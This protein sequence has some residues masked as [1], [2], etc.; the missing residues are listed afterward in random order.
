MLLMVRLPPF[1][2][3][4]SALREGGYFHLLVFSGGEFRFRDLR[5]LGGFLLGENLQAKVGRKLWGPQEGALHLFRLFFYAFGGDVSFSV[6]H[7]PLGLWCLPELA[8]VRQEREI[9]VEE[10]R[11]LSPPLLLL[12]CWTH[13]A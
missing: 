1:L 2:L 13:Q 3:G 6:H 10:R 7:L 12:A 9:L 5:L 4:I 11:A 8:A